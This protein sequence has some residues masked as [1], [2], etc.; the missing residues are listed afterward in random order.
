MFDK[1]EMEKAGIK[2]YSKQLGF[3]CDWERLPYLQIQKRSPRLLNPH[4][5]ATR[6][7][8]SCSVENICMGLSMV[9]LFIMY[10]DVY[11]IFLLLTEGSCEK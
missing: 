6:D 5:M 1:D 8:I 11:P 4:R 3:I 9:Y 7:K 2:V 10:K